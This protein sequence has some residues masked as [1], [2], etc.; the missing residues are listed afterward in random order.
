MFFALAMQGAAVLVTAVLMWKW[1][2]LSAG[3]ATFYGGATA[4]VNSGLLAW[5]WWRGL[6]DYQCDG[7]HHLKIFYR[8]CLER[9]FVVMIFLVA[10]L[11]LLR[12]TPL[13]MLIGFIV[14][15]LAWVISV[16]AL[17]TE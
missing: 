11:F 1:Q 17:K 5:R 6:A 9:F 16:L 7:W 12:L 4:V 10:G 2:G 8:S 3:N 13:P 14:G 15:L